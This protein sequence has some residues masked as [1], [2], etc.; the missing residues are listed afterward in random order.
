MFSTRLLPPLLLALLLAACPTADDDDGQRDDD[1]SAE[2]PTQGTLA[3]SFRIDEDWAAAMDEPAL[4]PF[5]AT[6]FRTDEVSGVGPDDGAQE[7]ESIFVQE[8][9]LTGSGLSS[10]TLYVTGELN[11][12]WVTV[13]GFLDSDSNS[14]EPHRPDEG[15]PVTLPNDNAFEVIGG[16]ETPVE[17][18]FDFLNL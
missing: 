12:G 17:V 4:G 10:P 9:D 7:L 13:L 18:L 6:I 11:A 14:V 15:D 3:I 16:E 5:R 1:D 8:V 2:A